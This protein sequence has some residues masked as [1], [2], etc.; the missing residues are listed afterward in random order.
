M[1]TT[2]KFKI[3]TAYD[4]IAIIGMINA[5]T[6]K[7]RQFDKDGQYNDFACPVATVDYCNRGEMVEGLCIKGRNYFANT[8]V[9][10]HSIEASEEMAQRCK[11]ID[12]EMYSIV[13]EMAQKNRF[14]YDCAK[15]IR[16][17]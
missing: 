1:N 3:G 12:A 9:T 8:E 2:T 13:I 5:R 16:R 17:D 10:E 15:A 11:E 7:V 14:A 6:L 4:N